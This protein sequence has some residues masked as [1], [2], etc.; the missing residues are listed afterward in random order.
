MQ[1]YCDDVEVVSGMIDFGKMAVGGSMGVVL[2][3]ASMRFPSVAR[4]TLVHFGS[5]KYP[6]PCSNAIAQENIRPNIRQ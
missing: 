4:S 6:W 2:E 1:L 5:H 3:K